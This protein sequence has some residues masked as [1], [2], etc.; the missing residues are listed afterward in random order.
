MPDSADDATLSDKLA[1]LE[2][3]AMRD[4]PDRDHSDRHHRPRPSGDR[5][6]EGRRHGRCAIPSA[7]KLM[8]F[9]MLDADTSTGERRLFAMVDAVCCVLAHNGRYGGEETARLVLETVVH[10]TVAK[11]AV[12][13]LADSME[14]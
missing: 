5:C 13:L 10:P 11:A 1:N 6:R 2:G 3:R 4:L 7:A 8:A 12:R 14:S 9:E